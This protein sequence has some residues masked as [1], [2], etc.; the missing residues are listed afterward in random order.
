[1]TLERDYTVPEVAAAL[2]MSK[3]WV[4]A[5]I[6]NGCAHQ[7]PS[8]NRIRFTLAQVDALR[9]KYESAPMRTNAVTTGRRKAS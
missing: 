9:A 1:M 3:R 5:Q 2:G 6:A 8:S 7:R 4:Y